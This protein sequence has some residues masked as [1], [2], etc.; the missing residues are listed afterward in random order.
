MFPTEEIKAKLAGMPEEE[1][2]LHEQA[3]LQADIIASD[4][5]I[6]NQKLVDRAVADHKV[7]AMIGNLIKR[8]FQLYRTKV[9]AGVEKKVADRYFKDALN[10]RVGKGQKIF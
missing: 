7:V 1:R 3:V 8:A 4:L 2:K 6:Y 10:V 9:P 5:Y